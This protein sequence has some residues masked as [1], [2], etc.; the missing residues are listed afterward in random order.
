M[1]HLIPNVA[2]AS[3]LAALV[4]HTN[5]HPTS[6]IPGPNV[7]GI[8][9]TTRICHVDST[10]LIEGLSLER[11]VGGKVGGVGDDIDLPGGGVRPGGGGS[12]SNG[13]GDGAPSDSTGDGGM[14]RSGGT[15][16]G[17]GDAPEPPIPV[18]QE[19]PPSARNNQN[20]PA[21]SA[22]RKYDPAGQNKLVID[23]D[24]VANDM[25]QQIRVRGEEG[26]PWY[27][28]DGLELETFLN[29]VRPILSRKL[30]L[31]DEN[32]N[33]KLIPSLET[34]KKPKASDRFA[35]QHED[36]PDFQAYF[37]NAYSKAYGQAVSGKTYVVIP[38]DR[39]INQP[40]EDA[41]GSWWWSFEAPE[42]S[43]NP[44]VEEINIV[45]IDPTMN[46]DGEL[47]DLADPIPIW[48]AGD[49][50]LGFR[51]DIEFERAFPPE[52]FNP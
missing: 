44:N 13:P 50:P 15:T 28:F 31:K 14:G 12:G 19:F 18:V 38:K 8:I 7:P 22:E 32:G 23:V 10:G 16:G 3:L 24:E 21:T 52:P 29:D 33:D 42:L 25:R 27:F 43:R 40:F 39:P 45:R 6:C 5:G 49:E 37:W 26:G 46:L 48:K 2:L 41:Q 51:A 30:E 35:M 11:R 17:M 34:A 4:L 20:Q 36:S 9:A 1:R 47:Y